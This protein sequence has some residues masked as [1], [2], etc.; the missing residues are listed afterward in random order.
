MYS[1]SNC[2]TI[3]ICTRIVSFSVVS[4]LTLLK[5]EKASFLKTVIKFSF[6][7]RCSRFFKC[8]MAAV[9]TSDRWFFDNTKC[10]SVLPWDEIE[11][12]AKVFKSKLEENVILIF[13]CTITY[14]CR[15]NVWLGILWEVWK[16]YF[17]IRFK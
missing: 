3:F 9:G 1:M 14:L 12:G 13:V 16:G 2:L 15:Y 5:P 7:L 10:F 8:L 4:R 6:R 11:L 17:L